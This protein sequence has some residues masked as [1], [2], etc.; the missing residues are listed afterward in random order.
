MRR[1]L[2]VAL[3]CLSA[4]LGRAQ[5]MPADL[6]SYI[7]RA[8]KTFEVPGLSISVVKD[9]KVLLSK[10]YG[11]ADLKAGTAVSAATRFGIASNTK[12]FTATALALLVDEGKIAWED[13]VQKHLPGFALS[14]PYI[15]SE[16]TVRDLLCHRSGLSLGAGDLLFWPETDFTADELVARLRFVPIKGRFRYGFA[17]D[18]VLYVVAGQLIE[19]VTK[20][21]WGEFVEK[22]ILAPVGMTRSSSSYG[23]AK[24]SGDI[25]ATYAQVDGKL[26]RVAPFTKS[27][28]GAAGGIMSC[29]DDMGKWMMTQL[30]RGRVSAQK[31][32]FSPAQSRELW[33]SAVIMPSRSD[34]GGVADSSFNTYALG[35]GVQEYRGQWHL[36][37]TGGLPGYTSL[38]SMYP[39]QNLGISVLTNA[40][41]GSAWMAI[42]RHI[43]DSF[44]GA[45]GADWIETFKHAESVGSSQVTPP[46]KVAGTKPSLELAGYVGTFRD[47]WY[48]DVIV[49]QKGSGL[50]ISFSRTP[51]LVGE[52]VHWHYNTF[53]VKWTDRTI[54]GDAL[55]TF[56][57]DSR[58]QVTGAKMV[59]FDS[60]VD[61]SFD[62]QDLVLKKTKSTGK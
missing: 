34:P 20:Q 3:C 11:K 51:S 41:A 10:G 37:H 54:R 15:S 21:K 16:L 60:N 57:F 9:G 33:S 23:G 4:C 55:M 19:A 53:W 29:S 39:N 56:E 30:A 2:P 8:M 1:L 50:G 26:T 18:N 52:L 6:D 36:F 25:A 62:Y 31:Q 7:L 43:A 17:Y 45:K 40:E 14:D 47:A 28:V 58:G 46:A 12:L 42:E 32:L 49:K 35:I 59:P 13:K 5:G 38:V 61:F 24:P 27:L 22:R 44:L 48:G